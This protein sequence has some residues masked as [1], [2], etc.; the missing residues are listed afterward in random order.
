MLCVALAM[1]PGALHGQVAVSEI[2]Y[3]LDGAD[4]KREWVEIQNTGSTPLD[5]AKWKINDGSNHVL[6]VPPK[7][8]GSGETLIAPGQYVIIAADAISFRSDHPS[9]SVSVIDSTLSL[10][11]ESDNISL[12]NASGTVITSASYTKSLGAA[13]DGNTLNLSGSSYI[14][15]A[16]SPGVTM[17]STAI[18]PKAKPAATPKKKA[19]SRMAPATEVTEQNE[20]DY[21]AEEG[22]IEPELSTSSQVATASEAGPAWWLGAL[23]IAL[24]GSGVVYATR[25]MK[26]DEWDIIDET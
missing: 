18:P 17:A 21:V 6:N 16:P 15:R 10:G 4:S 14:A 23:G 25:R 12:L 5:L 9:V 1:T 20:S 7:N 8:G 26:R 24:F 13:G 2:M 3:D 22:A 19:A 11:N